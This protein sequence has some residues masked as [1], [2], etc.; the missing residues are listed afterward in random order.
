MHVALF[1][2]LEKPT[3]RIF[4]KRF[5]IPLEQAFLA[6]KQGSEKGH[7]MIKPKAYILCAASLESFL[8]LEYRRDGEGLASSM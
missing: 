2:N 1:E 8:L 5:I 4:F 7:Q 6:N 3:V